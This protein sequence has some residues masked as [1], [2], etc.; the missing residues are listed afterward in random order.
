MIF[1]VLVNFV[2]LF[3]SY[4]LMYNGEFPIFGGYIFGFY[5][6]FTA[7]LLFIYELFLGDITRVTDV[8]G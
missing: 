1:T 7:S 2:A 5:I 3:Q 4:L 8:C 6:F